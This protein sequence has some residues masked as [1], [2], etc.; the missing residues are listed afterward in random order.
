[1][2]I[3][4]IPNCDTMKKAF[5]SLKE[6]KVGYEFHDYKKEGISK[7]KLKEWSKQVGWETILNKR[8]TTWKELGE[9]TQ[10]KITNETAAIQLMQEYTSIIKRPVLETKQGLVVG[11]DKEAYN[12]FK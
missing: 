5:D 7:E 2:K 10:K 8:S 12:S 3:Y 9:A 6:N 1:M 4:G 11:F